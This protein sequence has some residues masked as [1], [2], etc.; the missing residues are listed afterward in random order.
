M[1]NNLAEILKFEFDRRAKKN[2][3]YSLR[4][5]AKFIDISP[6]SL[7]R[8]MN[9][10]RA[11]SLKLEK[12]ILNKLEYNFVTNFKSQNSGIF[13][14]ISI[15][16]LQMN[17]QWTPDAIL[18]LVKIKPFKLTPLKIAKIFNIKLEEAKSSL[19][20]LLKKNYLIKENDNYIDTT[21]GTSTTYSQGV[22]S[23]Q[24]K[25]YQMSVIQ[26]AMDSLENETIESRHH[27]AVMFTL[28]KKQLNELKKYIDS[29][30]SELLEKFE[31]ND[32]PDSIYHCSIQ[33][34]PQTKNL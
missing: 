29:F 15:E 14:E 34:F 33:L 23:K 4:A 28:N 12:T 5:F 17:S 24:K 13:K 18:E 32:D 19:K 27:T 26:R 11:T 16:D 3:S 22:T 31:N 25:N 6:S 8:I 30:R 1:K 7:S 2:A 21:G 10:K 20:W 9:G